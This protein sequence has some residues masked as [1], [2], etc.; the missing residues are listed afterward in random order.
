MQKNL[1]KL[2]DG[3]LINIRSMHIGTLKNNETVTGYYALAYDVLRAEGWK[4]LT[5][6]QMPEEIDGI[7]YEPY[8]E[9]TDTEIFQRYRIALPEV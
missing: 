1:W 3:K 2:Q 7:T 6:E 8:C 9:E 5:V 4:P